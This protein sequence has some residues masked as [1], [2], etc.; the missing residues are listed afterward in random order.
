LSS[1]SAEEDIA[2]TIMRI[3][4]EKN[5]ETVHQ[6]SSLVKEEA[7]LSEQ[8]VLDEV[9]KL[10]SEGKIVL[11]KPSEPVPCSFSSY[12]KTGHARWYWMTLVLASATALIVF[13]VPEDR[14]PL[15]YIRNVLGTVFVLWLPGYS[16]T[17]ALFPKRAEKDASEGLDLLERIAL[18]IGLSLALVPMIGLLLN[19]TPWGI[20]LTPIT[21]SLL[22]FT[23]VAATAAVAREQQARITIA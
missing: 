11:K 22:A 5:P 2:K 4:Q 21:I 14:L 23:A 16:L 13:T 15:A 1:G 7:E 3:I 19:Y 17:K 20:R 8:K 6:L 12:L 10:Q 9:L 18:S